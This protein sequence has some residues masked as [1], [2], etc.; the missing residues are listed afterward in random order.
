MDNDQ[1]KALLDTAIDNI[2]G[3]AEITECVVCHSEGAPDA[4]IVIQIQMLGSRLEDDSA[5]MAFQDAG[6]SSFGTDMTLVP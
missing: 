4:S 2:P 5:I 6:Q 1:V 3:C